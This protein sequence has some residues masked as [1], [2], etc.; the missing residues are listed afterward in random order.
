MASTIWVTNRERLQKELPVGSMVVLFSGESPKK[1]AD[2]H[3]PFTPN[4][5]FYYMS[6]ID[7]EKLMLILVKEQEKWEEILFIQKPDPV[8]AKWVGKTIEEEEARERSGI[9]DIRY[10]ENFERTIHGYLNYGNIKALYVDLER[11]S[12]GSSDSRELTFAKT[13]QSKYPYVGIQ[14]VYPMICRLRMIKSPEEIAYL[15]EAIRITGEGIEA[16]MK[17]AKPGM[18]EYALEAHFDFVLKSNGIKDHAFKTIAASGQNATILHY[19]SNDAIIPEDS[20]I[21]FDL[22]AQYQYYNADISRTIPAAGRFTE[23]QKVFYQMV[24]DAQELV[25]AAI[26]PGVTL[27][28]LNEIVKTHYYEKLK[29]IGLVEKQEDVSKYYYHGVSHFLGL[30]THDVGMGHLPLEPGMVITVEP[31]FYYEEEAIGIR[32][33]D[34]VLVTEDGAEVLS[35][36]LI[37]TIEAVEEFMT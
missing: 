6:G 23:R 30:D 16:L 34:D 18:Y 11:D 36:E 22:G 21:L 28:E 33:E 17:N 15:K 24:L 12:W 35:K 5:N 29:E 3:Y 14:N 8:M 1:S 32:I 20:L 13:C 4:R 27:R 9:S 10:V 37:K 2:E 19:E 26:K 31:G 25:I 7:E